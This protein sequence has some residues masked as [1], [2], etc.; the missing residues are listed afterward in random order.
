MQIF[1]VKL[2]PTFFK[3][4]KIDLYNLLRTFSAGE[5]NRFG[6]F[7]QARCLKRNKRLP[8]VWAEI[9]K[10]YPL[11]ADKKFN[12]EKLYAKLYRKRSYNDSTMRS[13]YY[14]LYLLAEKFL[15]EERLNRNYF[16]YINF[17][18]EELNDR[19]QYN[20]VRK[21]LI[22]HNKK[23][24]VREYTSALYFEKYRLESNRF[25]FLKLSDAIHNKKT[26]VRNLKVLNKSDEYLV[27]FF[28]AE[29]VSD[30]VNAEIQIRKYNLDE[31]SANFALEILT[32][33]NIESVL[34]SFPQDSEYYFVLRIYHQLFKTFKDFDKLSHY[35]ELKKFVI[36][37]KHLFNKDELNKLY[38]T[39]MAYC[40]FKKNHD[41][42]NPFYK[43]ELLDLYKTYLTEEYYI[44]YNTRYLS[45]TTYRA[46][47]L[48]ALELK[49]FSWAETLVKKYTIRLQPRDIEN[50]SYFAKAMYFY[51]I[52]EPEQALE[53]AIKI[54]LENFIYKYDIKNLLLKIY[55]DTK[56]HESLYCL[57][58]TY[59]EFLKN[60]T[61]LTEKGKQFYRK[62]ID[63]L[64]K[65][66]YFSDGKTE[67]DIDFLLHKIKNE[68]DFY[69][70]EWLV[71]KYTDRIS[72]M[73][74]V[75]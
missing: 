54:K 28:V 32:G 34:S 22:N 27:V 44:D 66:I 56:K 37:Y 59:R 47:L 57:I 18:L 13:F 17:L 7:V 55:T 45:A 15:V 21:T 58:H 60:D 29:I 53:N 1:V 51:N 35:L 65:L 31:D 42:E 5:M 62:F 71:L 9:K 72:K 11:F 14:Q 73:V 50:M 33:L 2:L 6:N 52:N 39:L 3:M 43:A 69:N 48:L 26:A 10:Q 30:F 41:S 63:Y 24:H 16:S 68:K 64:E 46:T 23:L 49:D 12:K 20:L 38:S 36:S 40:I 4:F 19:S 8:V 75:S 70:K 67:I 74:K 61:L 25:N